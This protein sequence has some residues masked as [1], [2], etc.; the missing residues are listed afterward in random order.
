MRNC[1]S[2]S[3]R[4]RVYSTLHVGKC[5]V[6]DQALVARRSQRCSPTFVA[7]VQ[8]LALVLRNIAVDPDVPCIT[9]LHVLYESFQ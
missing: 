5:L 2:S 4:A 9:E 7:R 3:F 8:S 1:F 6:R